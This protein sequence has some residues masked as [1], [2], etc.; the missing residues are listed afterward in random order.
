MFSGST[1]FFFKGLGLGF[2]C[3]SVLFYFVHMETITGMQTDWLAQQQAFTEQ[4]LLATRKTEQQQIETIDLLMKSYAISDGN[5]DV[6]MR[7][8]L[9]ESG[10]INLLMQ[11]Q[12][13]T[14]IDV[15]DLI[16]Q[17]KPFNSAQLYAA[18]LRMKQAQEKML[19][20]AQLDQRLEQI[21]KD[22]Q[23]PAQH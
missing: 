7:A 14:N 4:T 1:G 9:I 20:R 16:D 19:A 22:S 2:G 8:V 21:S 15:S 12:K 5:E 10:H 18:L 3:A 17:A 11:V 13:Q 6:D 23:Q